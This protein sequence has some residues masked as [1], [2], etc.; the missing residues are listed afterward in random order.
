M[1]SL[2]AATDVELGSQFG[3]DSPAAP[4]VAALCVVAA[5][6]VLWA[7]ALAPKRCAPLSVNYHFT[8][9]C[10]YECRF[11]FHTAKTSHLASAE[12]WKRGLTM[13]RDAGMRKIN[14]SGGEPFLKP[15]MLG[16]MVRF[17]KVELGLSV[18]IVSNGS[19]IREPWLAENGKYVDYIALSCDSTSDETCLAIGR[20]DRQQRGDHIAKIRC[21]AALLEKY[22]VRLRINT[23]VTKAS[24]DEDMSAFIEALR[25]ARWKVFQ[26]LLVKG[27]NANDDGTARSES[28]PADANGR[29][30][31][32]NKR[33]ADDLVLTDAEFQRFVARHRRA[34][35]FVASVIVPESNADMAN[36]YVILD[37]YLRL[38]DTSS[39]AKIPSR[40][41]TEVG[42][43][44]ALRES[45]GF[46][47][48]AF[49]RRGGIYDWF[50]RG[51]QLATAR[52]ADPL[53]DVEDLMRA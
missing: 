25:P 19:L 11:C 2:S 51:P 39:G 46:D 10:N 24:C 28:G 27:E 40:P 37:E 1:N 32:H 20:H 26:M 44:A 3:W 45:N 42:V 53:A 52:A 15:K 18:T 34:S 36:S 14:F 21:A 35:A 43:E 12:D 33:V 31:F 5:C 8:R 49:K 17:C 30:A 23:T 13:L 9:E 41:I 7:S 48:S 6:Y 22:N 4:I 38:L 16:E 47:Y 29:G 50:R